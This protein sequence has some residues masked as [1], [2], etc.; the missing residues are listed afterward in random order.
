MKE[1]KSDIRLAARSADG[2]WIMTADTAGAV[3]LRDTHGK[4]LNSTH[5]NGWPRVGAFSPDGERL[6]IAGT[7]RGVRI[8]KTE[9]FRE[10]EPI[11][12]TSRPV[13]ALAMTPDGGH[14][15][16]GDTYGTLIVY[17]ITDGHREIQRQSGAPVRFVTFSKTGDYFLVGRRNGL[18]EVYKTDTGKIVFRQHV[19]GA[20]QAG[21]FHP[22]RLEVTFGAEGG[23]I[24]RGN[25]QTPAI[26]MPMMYENI[27]FDTKE[28]SFGPQNIYSLRYS[29]DGSDLLIADSGQ[30][31]KLLHGKFSGHVSILRGHA[32][33]IFSVAYS[34]DGQLLATAA[35]DGEIRIWAPPFLAE[36]LVLARHPDWVVSGAF[37]TDGALV[38]TGTVDGRLHVWRSDGRGLIWSMKVAEGE[39]RDGWLRSITV[40]SMGKD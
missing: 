28:L 12:G 25:K 5:L 15:L 36:P 2:R 19:T 3:Y 40:S 20:I 10:L 35:S 1:H 16:T 23:T 29:P 31:I 32:P 34:K 30:E 17:D 33:G 22:E 9:G 37:Q 4:V 6:F 18:G 13:V 14:L 39:N 27:D 8:W 21:D 38:A 11:S 24:I 7:K 26:S